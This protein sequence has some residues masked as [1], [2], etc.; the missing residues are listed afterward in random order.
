MPG[1]VAA[2]AHRYTHTHAYVNAYTSGGLEAFRLF[3]NNQL[4]NGI[5]PFAYSRKCSGCQWAVRLL[6]PPHRDYAWVME[7][8]II[9]AHVHMRVCVYLKPQSLPSKRISSESHQSLPCAERFPKVNWPRKSEEFI[10]L[11]IIFSSLNSGLHK[12]ATLAGDTST[13]VKLM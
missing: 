9:Y 5:P 10:L 4:Q 3:A 1:G 13:R 7:K 8:C 6:L 11:P 12:I 2:A